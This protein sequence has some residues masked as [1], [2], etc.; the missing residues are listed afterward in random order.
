LLAEAPTHLTAGGVV[1]LEIAFDQ[2]AAVRALIEERLPG[3]AVE[4]RR[5]LAGHERVV[6]IQ[7]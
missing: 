1:I 4:V 7:T 5:D 2:G 6:V 3:A